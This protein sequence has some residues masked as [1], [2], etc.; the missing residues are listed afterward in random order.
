[1]KSVRPNLDAIF[2]TYFYRLGGRG[3]MA[4]LPLLQP[5]FERRL[6]ARAR[7]PVQNDVT[8]ITVLRGV[9]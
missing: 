6:I 8:S 2:I 1:M 3:R 9:T 7:N 4:L 5:K